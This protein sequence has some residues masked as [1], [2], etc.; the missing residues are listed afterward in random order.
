MQ[1]KLRW[2]RRAVKHLDAIYDF[3]AKKDEQ[4]A[5][6]V[7]N[8]LL[9]SADTLLTFSL[10]GKVEEELKDNLKE[11]RTLVVCKH[12][13][14]VYRVEKQIIKIV[15]VWDCRQNPTKLKSSLYK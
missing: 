14:L 1:V 12:Y 6:K 15:A 5:I 9:D 10:A 3:L 4:A 8:D 11:Y 7:Y 2:M 13:K